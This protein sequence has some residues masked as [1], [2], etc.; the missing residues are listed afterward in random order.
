M[1]VFLACIFHIAIDTTGLI[2]AGEFLAR[3]LTSI[4]VLVAIALLDPAVAIRTRAFL[5]GWADIMTVV[6]AMASVTCCSS[7]LVVFCLSTVG[8]T[9]RHCYSECWCILRK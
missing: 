7:C 2:A 4:T 3:S 9:I 6:R 8:A 1:E 5:S